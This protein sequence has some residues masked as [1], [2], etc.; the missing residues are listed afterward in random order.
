MSEAVAIDIARRRCQ[1]ARHPEWADMPPDHSR[2][3]GFF[4]DLC[5]EPPPVLRLRRSDDATPGAWAGVLASAMGL[6]RS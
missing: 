5:S 3:E 2:S 1:Q 6:R 4:E